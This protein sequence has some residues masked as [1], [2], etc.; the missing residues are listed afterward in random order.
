M[1]A[2][3]YASKLAIK[4]WQTYLKE[5]NENNRRFVDK[6]K[7]LVTIILSIIKFILWLRGNIQS[8]RRRIVEKICVE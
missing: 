5:E 8:K 7:Y 3:Q 1:S 4:R 6:S 2:D